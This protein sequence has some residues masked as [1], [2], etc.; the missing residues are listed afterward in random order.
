MIGNSDYSIPMNR[1]LKLLKTPNGQDTILRVAPYDFDFSGLVNASYALPSPDYQQ[2]SVRDRVFLGMCDDKELEASIKHFL[3]KKEEILDCVADF[4]LMSKASR[5]DIK[6]Y[7]KEFFE[8]IESDEA[9]RRPGK[10]TGH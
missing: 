10:V 2:Q 6:Q 8:E 3:D 1:N 9:I 7:L 4:K 5:I